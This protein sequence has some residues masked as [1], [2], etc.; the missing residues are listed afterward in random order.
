M[1]ALD[2]SL[3]VDESGWV[4]IRN[5]ASGS[6]LI[7][8]VSVVVSILGVSKYSALVCANVLK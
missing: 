3:G 2:F 5:S 7:S 1:L 4:I 6:G 8:G